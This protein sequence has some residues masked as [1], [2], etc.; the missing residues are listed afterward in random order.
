M[1][2]K[3]N[4]PKKLQPYSGAFRD[5]VSEASAEWNQGY[6]GGHRG[7]TWAGKSQ[8]AGS[9]AAQSPPYKVTDQGIVAGAEHQVMD[10]ES[11]RIQHLAPNLVPF[12]LDN[13]HENVIEA[14]NNLTVAAEAVH[15]CLTL[16]PTVVGDKEQ[17]LQDILKAMEQHLKGLTKISDAIQKHWS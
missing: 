3:R 17:E 2:Q 14:Y 11:E 6:T 9:V 15:S 7:T 8:A 13:I 5:Q 10:K 1:P 4:K 16:N 12:P